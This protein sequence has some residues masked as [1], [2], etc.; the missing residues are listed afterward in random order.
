MDSLI[1]KADAIRPVTKKRKLERSSR[2]KAGPSSRTGK[3]FDKTASSIAHNTVVPKSLRATDPPPEGTRTYKH[4]QN[5]KLRTELTRQSTHA[6]RAKELLKDAELLLQ[7]EAGGIQV[8]DEMER[9][10]RLG[11]T[12]ITSGAGE[13]SAKGRKE[14]RLDAGPYRCRYTRNGRHLAIVGNKGHVSTF[15]WQTGTMHSELHLQETCR[16]ITFLH[17]HSHYAVAQKK[18]VFIYDRDGV[19]LHRLKSH[20]EPTR[21]EFLPY[22]WLLASVGNT[23][24]LK[25]QDTSTGQLLVEHRTKLGACNVMTQ[26][27]HN[28][29]IHLGHQNGTVTLWTPNLPHPAVRLLA[30]LGPLSSVSVDPSTGGR[31]MATAGKDGTV[32]VWDCRNWKGEV[33]S[34]TARGG[35]ADV[36]WSQRGMLAV[37]SGGTVNVYN[38]PSIQ[39]PFKG[40]TQPPLYLTHPIPHRPLT[41]TRFCPFQDILTVGH[42]AGLSSILVPGSGEPNFDSAEADPFENRQARREREVRSLLD[43]IQ[44]D[45]ITLDPEFI[46][47]L[48]PPTKLTTAVNGKVD[49]PYARLPR[50]ERLRV[51]GKAD[52]TEA[53]GSSEEEAD[54]GDGNKDEHARESKATK[55][56]KKMRGKNKSLK[57][58]L[59]KHRKNVIDP[60][61]VAVRAKLEREKEERRQARAIASGQEQPKKPSALDRFK[62]NKT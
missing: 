57:R 37:T 58:Y 60:Q 43:K 34:W 20:V 56:K 59:R 13:E 39:T 26:N 19:E 42:A 24:Y 52:E 6:A 32:K 50:L 3:A 5:R 41:S 55:E 45:A 47:T 4:I 35:E 14:W 25:Y 8:E 61:T 22:H 36:A 7:D 51:S 29:V 10:W 28:A 53:A 21:L 33:R 44:P 15:D 17:D 16:D 62:K 48:A 18:Y 23:G 54:E 40:V 30:H 31:Y 11:Q 49:T 9:T 27:T 1:A 46:G 12:D 2:G 38:K